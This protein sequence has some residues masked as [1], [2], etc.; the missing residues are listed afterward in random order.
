MQSTE[1]QAP[2]VNFEIPFKMIGKWCKT[3]GPDGAPPLKRAR[4]KYMYGIGG[5][6]GRADMNYKDWKK[7]Y[8]W[9]KDTCAPD[10]W[11]THLRKAGIG[12]Q[13]PD[14][15]PDAQKAFA[16]VVRKW[17]RLYN[18]HNAHDK[19]YFNKSD[20]EKKKSAAKKTIDISC[21]ENE[22]DKPTMDIDPDTISC[23]D[24]PTET[25]A[26]YSTIT[27]RFEN[28]F[29]WLQAVVRTHLPST[30]PHM[31]DCLMEEDEVYTPLTEDIR[32]LKVSTHA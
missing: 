19:V 4:D 29:T 3:V 17:G 28:N 6:L 5:A 13:R 20:T 14:Y 31:W 8:A 27:R 22:P 24:E 1:K 21:L 9:I 10:G 15:K 7:M 11:M 25:K 2:R 26:S 32:V 30:I 12:N 16:K 23:L 18:K